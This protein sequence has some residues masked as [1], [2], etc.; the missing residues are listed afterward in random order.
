MI[1]V[2]EAL[3]LAGIIPDMP[4]STEYHLERGRAVHR[5]VELAARGTL[6]ESSVH[7]DVAL[8]LAS[9]R[10]WWALARGSLVAAEVEVKSDRHG[11]VGHPDAIVRLNGVEWLLD[12]KTGGAAPWHGI[13]TALYAAAM[14]RP[15]RRGAVYLRADGSCAVLVPHRGISDYVEG[16]R[17][18]KIARDRLDN[19]ALSLK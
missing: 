2:T 1:R 14:D 12:W 11:Y 4:Y 6:D 10:A 15:L 16:L 5:A 7:L 18:V 13:Q 17:A 19:R 9:W 3:R 8:Y